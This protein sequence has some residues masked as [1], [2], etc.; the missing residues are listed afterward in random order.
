MLV[1]ALFASQNPAILQLSMFGYEL[2]PVSLTVIILAAA[3]L[4]ALISVFFMGFRMMALKR[5]LKKANK[6]LEKAGKSQIM[7]GSSP[8]QAKRLEALENELEEEKA[9]KQ[10]LKKEVD[11][12]KEEKIADKTEEK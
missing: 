1:V 6:L 2:I 7:E 4:G 9:A 11:D 10:A 5:D 3:L 8:E 12:L